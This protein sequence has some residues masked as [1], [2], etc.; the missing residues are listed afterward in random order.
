MLSL[1]YFPGPV[2]LLFARETRG[3]G[4]L[5]ADQAHR[6]RATVRILG[7]HGWVS[8]FTILSFFPSA[9]WVR[10]HQEGGC[11]TWTKPEFK[12]IAVTFEVT[13]YAGRR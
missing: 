3:Q 1:A 5:R 4:W 10:D 6:F 7:L 11:M 2:T 8:C 12:E 9:R 13:A